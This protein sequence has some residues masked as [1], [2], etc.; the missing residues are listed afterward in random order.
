MSQAVVNKNAI[1]ERVIQTII[2]LNIVNDAL[3]RVESDSDVGLSML[4]FAEFVF[5]C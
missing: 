1:E 4:T 2:R 3:L 5:T